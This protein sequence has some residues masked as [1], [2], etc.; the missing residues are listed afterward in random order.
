[1]DATPQKVKRRQRVGGGRWSCRYWGKN[2]AVQAKGK[3]EYKQG[4]KVSLARFSN[5]KEASMAGANQT[6]GE[7]PGVYQRQNQWSDLGQEGH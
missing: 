3:S 7:N 6:K 2:T 5:R 1:M 4:A